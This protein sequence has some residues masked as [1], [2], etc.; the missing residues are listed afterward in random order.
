MRVQRSVLCVALTMCLGGCGTWCALG[1]CNAPPCPKPDDQLRL[2]VERAA[3][4]FHGHCLPATFGR[5][6]FLRTLHEPTT[7][8]G[9]EITEQDLGY[10][11]LVD[12]DIWAVN[13]CTDYDLVA[14]RKPNGE[15][16]LWDTSATPSGVD[17]SPTPNGGVPPSTAPPRTQATCTCSK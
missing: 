14:R 10:L 2:A 1:G 12:L 11:H 8:A 17:S 3:R 7:P 5:K 16:I 6:E 15:I 13:N 4:V 9:N